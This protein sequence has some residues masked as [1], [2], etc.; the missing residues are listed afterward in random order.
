ME[1]YVCTCKEPI[2]LGT[3]GLKLPNAI[4]LIELN[5]KEAN[6]WGTITNNT[7]TNNIKL[8]FLKEVSP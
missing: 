8:V 6:I 3:T 7:I 5:S 2:E 1:D 4:V